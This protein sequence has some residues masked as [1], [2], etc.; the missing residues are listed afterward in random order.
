[1]KTILNFIKIKTILTST[2]FLISC[3]SSIPQK[4]TLSEYQKIEIKKNEI[5]LKL[6]DQISTIE[7]KLKSLKEEQV[8]CR[9]N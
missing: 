8:S 2:I 1:M 5:I 4:P 6:K 7:K 9:K 3:S